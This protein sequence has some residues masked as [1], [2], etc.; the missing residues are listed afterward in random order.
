VALALERDSSAT[1]EALPLVVAL[2]G[3]ALV[4]VAARPEWIVVLGFALLAYVRD[5]PAPVDVVFAVLIVAVLFWQR[6]SLRLPPL[7]SGLLVALAVVTL[8]SMANADD[9]GWAVRFEAITLYLIA[10][11][12]C[13]VSVFASEDLT[14]RAVTAYIV[15]AAL[16]AL[17]AAIAVEINI[18]GRSYLTYGSDDFRAEGL[19]KDPNV[20]APFLVPA[21]AIVLEEMVRPRLLDWKMRWKLAVFLVLVLGVVLAFS[22]GAWVN[23]AVAVSTVVLIYAFRRRGLRAAGRALAVLVVTGLVGFSLLVGTGSL[24]FFESRSG[25]QAYD[26]DRFDT[27]GA[28]FERAT[29]HLLGYGP[30]QVERSLEISAHSLYARLAFEQGLLGVF[31]IVLLALVTLGFAVLLVARD[32]NVHGIGSVALLGAW[33]GMLANSIVIDTLHWRHLWIVAALIW[34][35]YAQYRLRAQERVSRSHTRGLAG[36]LESGAGGP[37]ANGSRGRSTA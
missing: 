4:L 16:S 15:V 12:I 6:E 27:Q 18:P 23:M 36:N 14:R 22:R 33:L 1:A 24:S 29:D 19:F 2:V 30:G 28:A 34:A 20:F 37:G 3:A 35:G 9:F 32:A 17:A 25:A 11:S 31:L 10:L 8:L 5:E 7:V 21:A 13:L 26:R